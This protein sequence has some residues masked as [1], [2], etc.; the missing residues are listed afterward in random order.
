VEE[1]MK[2]AML[3][4][5]RRPYLPAAGHDFFLPF[6]DLITKLIG[7]DKVRRR[8]LEQGELKAGQ[9]ILDLGCGTGTLAI[10]LKRA[11][12]QVEVVGLD[13]DPKALARAKHKAE[14][15]AVTPRFQQGYSDALPFPDS[16]LDHVF[17]SFVFHHLEPETRQATLREV[18]RV[19]KPGGSLHLVDFLRAESGDHSLRRLFQSHARLQD[20]SEE[21]MLK[22]MSEA[23]L[24]PTVA[25]REA[26]LFGLARVAYFQAG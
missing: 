22:L 17:S 4:D 5:N 16:S 10:E 24:S 6:Y 20:N 19:L 7:A 23:G 14:R 8:L 26:V 2:D 1:A 11:H 15:A 12:P 25:G 9:R 18:R 13:P 21:R 3:V